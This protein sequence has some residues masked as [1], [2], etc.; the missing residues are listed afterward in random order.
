M[1]NRYILQTFLFP[2]EAKIIAI[3]EEVFDI[4][5]V[6]SAVNA[7]NGESGQLKFYFSL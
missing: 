2:F 6:F 3:V 1:H 5:I 4:I 7:F